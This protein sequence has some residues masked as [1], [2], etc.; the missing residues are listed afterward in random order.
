ECGFS[1]ILAEENTVV[2]SR[3]ELRHHLEPGKVAC[4]VGT[5]AKVELDRVVSD[6]PEF[7]V[8]VRGGTFAMTE[9]VAADGA[10]VRVSGDGT[11]PHVPDW[12]EVLD[13]EGDEPDQAVQTSS[14]AEAPAPAGDDP[15]P[16]PSGDDVPHQAGAE[17]GPDSAGTG[18][19]MTQIDAMMGLQKVKEPIRSLL[20]TV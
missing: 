6:D 5:G 4:V 18:D 9:L 14:E 10:Y 13:A 16:A 7:A 11:V 20:Q 1:G 19:P 3:S 17:S 2:E 12:V 15:E 8:D